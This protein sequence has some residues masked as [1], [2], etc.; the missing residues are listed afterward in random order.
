MSLSLPPRLRSL[1]GSDAAVHGRGRP[2]QPGGAAAHPQAAG[3]RQRRRYRGQ[4]ERGGELRQLWTLTSSKLLH[5]LTD[6][7]FHLAL[8]LNIFKKAFRVF[9]FFLILK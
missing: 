3:R 9:F 2:L 4:R 1:S 5:N 6:L 8:L 7:L